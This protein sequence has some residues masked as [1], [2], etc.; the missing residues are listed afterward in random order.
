VYINGNLEAS[1]LTSSGTSGSSAIAD[2]SQIAASVE[3]ALNSNGW[4]TVRHGSTITITNFPTNG[5]LSTQGGTG[6]KSLR[7]FITDVQSFS[8]LPPTSPEGRLVRVAGDLEQQG[9]DY[10]V[11][12]N[13]GLWRETLGW[14]EAEKLNEATMPHVLVRNTDGTWT[15]K[16]HTWLNREVGDEESNRLPSF[17][18]SKINDIFVYTNRLGFLADE[19]IILSESDNYENFFRTTTAQLLDSDP[20]DL[21]VLHNNVDIMYHAVPYN[22]DLLIMSEKSQFRFTYNQFLGQKTAQILYSTSFN[23]SRRV[24]PVNVGNSVYLVDDR[25]DYGFTKLYEFYPKENASQDDADDVS[26]PVPELIPNNIVFMAASNRAK[27]VVVQSSV[28]PTSLY[29]Y[30]FFWAGDRKVQNAW[31]RWQFTDCEQIYWAGF[32]GTFLYLLIKRPLGVS[33]ERIRLDEDVFDTD[34]NYEVM[35]DRRFSPVT[36]TYDPVQDATFITLPY[37]TTAIP[38]VVSSDIPNGIAGITGQVTKLN[39]SEI[40]VAGNISTYTVTVGIPYTMM[41]EFSTLYA[42]QQK[43][44]GEVTMK[45]GR[46]QIR[47]LTVEYSNTALFQTQVITPG[48]DTATSTFVGSTV[49]NTTLGKLP[50]AS[51]RYRIPVMSENT[52]ARIIITNDSPFPSAFGSAEWQGTLSPKAVQRI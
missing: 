7:G 26:A 30:K 48:R 32:S 52:K 2:T 40:K 42:R 45:D 8:D 11:A 25:A 50:F 47:Y 18:G 9:D 27:S 51:G 34:L 13:K 20:I 39:N 33:L 41:Y 22:R 29:V 5:T 49:G 24:R 16:R 28:D 44:Q 6:D 14:D 23:V 4:T 19:N 15:F 43:G 3:A 21:A 38:Q 36:T 1:H 35:L 12:F 37:S 46:L 17:V 31:T 10:Y